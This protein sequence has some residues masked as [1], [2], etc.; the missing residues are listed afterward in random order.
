MEAYIEGYM[1]ED[2]D[3]QYPYELVRGLLSPEYANMS[4]Q[5]FEVVVDELFSNM[6][7]AQAEDF[8][9]ALKS[10]GNVVAGVLPTVGTIVG[11]IYGGPAGGAI[12]GTLGQ[13]VGGVA[14][15]AINTPAR[16]AGKPST[17]QKPVA[18][19]AGGVS[20]T[21]KAILSLVQNPQ[22]IQSLL[23]AIIGSAGKTSVQV[24]A[25]A[26]EADIGA[27]ANALEHLAG[28]L[29]EELDEAAG[30]EASER[31]PEYLYNDDGE[32]ACSDPAS[33]EERAEALLGLLG[34]DYYDDREDDEMTPLV[35]LARAGA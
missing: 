7:E 3:E 4:E 28:R 33:P 29:R 35:W 10:I 11:S 25:S 1:E 16:N 2:Y 19:G 31:L 5:N 18:V 14:S 22:F 34:E 21:S 13:V 27:F 12:G 15:K 9:S 32:L 17:T 26:K 24:G 23:G 8:M 30:S 6:S 20:D